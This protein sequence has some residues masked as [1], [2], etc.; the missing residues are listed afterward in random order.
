MKKI[1]ILI[2]FSFCFIS[3]KSESE[4][5]NE[6]Y[7][8][9]LQDLKNIELGQKIVDSITKNSLKNIYTDTTG[10]GNSPIKVYKYKLVEKEYSTSYKDIKLYYK[11]VSK[12]NISAIRFEWYGEN[13]FNEPADMGSSINLGAGGGFTDELLKVGASDNG[14]WE[15]SS[16]DVKK[17]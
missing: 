4:K 8:K 10:V 9:E 15:I 11:N 17:K 7:D 6:E 1:I 13:A 16:N 2:C 12:K 14:I 5:R 3:C